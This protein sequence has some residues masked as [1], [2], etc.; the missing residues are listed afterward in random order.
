MAH[1]LFRSDPVKVQ[2]KHLILGGARSGKSTYAEQLALGI[3]QVQKGQLFYVATATAEDE[4]MARRITRHQKSRT[5][6]W[7][8]IE[9][10]LVLA[11]AIADRNRQDV[12]L[13]DCLTLWLSNCLHQGRWSV[14]RDNFFKSI[15]S[16]PATIILV[17]N[18]V[19]HGIVPLGELSRQFIDQ[20]GWLH[21]DLAKLCSDV[22]LI[23]AGLPLE[24]K[25]SR[26][27]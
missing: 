9:E 10:P 13:V 25:S 1:L 20:S 3:R 18:E 14:E 6:E 21:Q 16:S 26:E 24:L 7:I 23:S 4:E 17:S 15:E 19:G 11:E 8:V 2:E 22:T 5:R 27:S 12:V